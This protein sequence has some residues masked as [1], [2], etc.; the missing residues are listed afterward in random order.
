M[1]MFGL[2]RHLRGAAVGH[3]AATELTSSPGSHRIVKGL[4]RLALRDPASTF[5]GNTSRPTRFM[6]K[7]SA[8][9]SWQTWCRASPAWNG[10]SFSV[11][12][13]FDAIEGRLADHMLSSWAAGCPSLQHWPV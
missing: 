11:A 1:S 7:W 2:H 8:R 3:F 9:T 12:C 4:K 10:T 6:N 13:A 5:I